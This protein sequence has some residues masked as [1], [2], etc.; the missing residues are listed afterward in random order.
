MIKLWIPRMKSLV[1]HGLKIPDGN[2]GKKV[3]TSPSEISRGLAEG[4]APTF[5]AKSIPIARASAYAKRF[6]GDWDWTLVPKPSRN[7]VSLVLER[8]PNSASG[9]DGLP[10]C[11]WQEGGDPAVDTLWGCTQELM[12]GIL[13]PA[14]FS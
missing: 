7:T 6:K 5:A 1:L 2:G 9:P 10:Y 3:V 12:D 11:V 14:D 13:P 8:L 4:W